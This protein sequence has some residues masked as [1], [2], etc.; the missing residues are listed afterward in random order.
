MRLKGL[1]ITIAISCLPLLSML[2]PGLPLTHDGRD[3][4]AR[5]ANFYQSLSE[6]NL[7]PRW[8]ANLNW[9]Y[10]HPI[11]MFLYPLP[12]YMASIFHVLGF[13]LVDSTKLVFVVSYVLSMV[14]MYLWVSAVWGEPAGVAAAVVY[15]YSPYRFVDLYVRGA[16]GEHVAFIFPPLIG[17]SIWK[18]A[19]TMKIYYWLILAFSVWGLVLSHNAVSLMIAPLVFLYMVYIWI[20]ETN[21][22]RQFLISALVAVCLAFLSS[23]FFWFPAYIEGK[24]TLRDIV[25]RGEFQ[26]RF[27]PIVKLFYS[28]WSYG[29][30]GEL[31]KEVGLLQWLVFLAGIIALTGNKKKKSR[32]YLGGILTATVLALFLM[33]NLSSEVWQKITLLQKFQFPWRF[34]TIPV[35]TAAAGIGL[36]LVNFQKQWLATFI[37]VLL[38]IFLSRNQHRPQDYLLFADDYFK[39]VFASTTDTGESSPIWSVR[40]MERSP[41][42]PLEIISGSAQIRPLARSTTK[43]TYEVNARL[44]TRLLE[45]TLYFPGWQ[46]NID[47]QAVIIEFQDPGYRGLMTFIV[48]A[49]RH[50]V[51]VVFGDTKVRRVA[52]TVSIMSV[53]TVGFIFTYTWFTKKRLSSFR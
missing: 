10:G 24:Y 7:V 20:Y 21:K 6:G 49:G 25:T 37:I 1:L 15:G 2:H 31:S 3:H 30:A 11:L 48:P 41:A 4:V 53:I 52:N 23:S 18:L 40:F 17:L 13:S 19:K 9:G 50:K 26:N 51:D 46:V 47:G 16:L 35:L 34:L 38:A 12:S 27:V 22:S 5:T 42:A 45:N 29:G 33:T 39:A 32:I 36:V 43:H 14:F 28:K 8:A 44:P